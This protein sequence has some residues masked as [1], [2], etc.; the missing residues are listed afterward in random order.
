M[1]RIRTIKP[2][3]WSS[4]TLGKVSRESRLTFIGLWNLCDDIGVML[5]IPKK[6]AGDLYPW[7]EISGTQINAELDELQSLGLI[8]R[9]SENNKDFIII[10]SWDEHQKIDNPGKPHYISRESRETL[11][12][13]YP[14]DIGNRS[15][16][17][18]IRSKE[19]K[20]LSSKLDDEIKE[21]Q[22]AHNG[23]GSSQE[24]KRKEEITP[25]QIDSLDES[26]ALQNCAKPD[27]C[28][29]IFQFWQ[30]TMKH[31]KCVLDKKREARIKWAISKYELEDIKKAIVGC[32]LTPH[33]MGDNKTG[34]K[35]DDIELILRDASHVEVFIRNCEIPPVPKINGSQGPPSKQS[36]IKN[37][38]RYRLTTE[39]IYADF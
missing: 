22:N 19:T 35:Y 14:L 13:A 36:G 27:A 21:N 26:G 24:E 10:R 38:G 23:H 28:E 1:A 39:E 3:F 15:K 18:G 30:T 31:T 11:A 37:N 5:D 2:D 32:S 17:I 33:N 4:K 6:I 20:D 12:R 25:A 16:E 34:A 29:E 9:A 7:E 8:V